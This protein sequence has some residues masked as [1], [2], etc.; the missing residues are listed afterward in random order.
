MAAWRGGARESRF[1]SW[2]GHGIAMRLWAKS[3]ISLHL[4]G[5]LVLFCLFPKCKAWLIA[6]A[7]LCQSFLEHF[8]GPD[9][10]PTLSLAVPHWAQLCQAWR[11]ASAWMGLCCL[12]GLHT[13]LAYG[14][15]C[16]FL[17]GAAWLQ[18]KAFGT[19]LFSAGLY[20]ISPPFL[21]F[22][23][24]FQIGTS[25]ILDFKLQRSLRALS[26]PSCI[27]WHTVNLFLASTPLLP[28]LPPK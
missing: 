4:K 9:Y 15:S 26:F 12:S 7:G 5:Q 23:F 24:P 20:W 14:Y 10:P 3:Y 16:S 8:C 28:S 1:K 18:R 11:N 17:L 25:F 22:F 13:P 2:L 27:C 6:E 19:L 21:F